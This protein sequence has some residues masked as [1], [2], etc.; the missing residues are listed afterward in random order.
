MHTHSYKFAISLPAESFKL[1]CGFQKRFKLSRSAVIREAI[2]RLTQSRIEA[3]KMRQ[4]EKGY[5]EF[6]PSG[7]ES[8]TFMRLVPETLTP[9]D[10]E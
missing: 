8:E 9:E 7:A 6:P 4:Y 10:W 1:L 5:R 2:N 3:R